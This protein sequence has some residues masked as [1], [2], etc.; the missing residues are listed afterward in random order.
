MI[1]L[2]NIF[3]GFKGANPWMV[4]LCL[5]FASIAQ[6]FGI[7]SLVPLI[8]MV[9]DEQGQTSSLAGRTVVDVLA[10]SAWRRAWKSCWWSSSSPSP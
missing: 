9:G 2:F 6:G 7:A 8:S 4:V 10:A 1:R 5:L 3:F